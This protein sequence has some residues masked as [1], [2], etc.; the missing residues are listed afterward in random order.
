M[1]KVY[2]ITDKETG[3]MIEQCNTY[4]EALKILN[5]FEESDKEEG[6]FEPDFYEIVEK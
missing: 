4:D 1:K 2:V 3:T 6:I 5:Q